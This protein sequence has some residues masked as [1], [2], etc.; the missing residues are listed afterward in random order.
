[1]HNATALFKVSLRLDPAC[2]DS[3][4]GLGIALLLNLEEA[5]V[6]E[7]GGAEWEEAR[8]MPQQEQVAFFSNPQQEKEKEKKIQKDVLTIFAR[9]YQVA[10]GLLHVA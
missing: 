9:A 7:G 6:G 1:V 2:V 4:V 8:D 3:L 10:S 5:E